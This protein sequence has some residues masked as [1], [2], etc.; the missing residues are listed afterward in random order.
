MTTLTYRTVVHASSCG[1]TDRRRRW[2]DS[3]SS[4]PSRRK[5]SRWNIGSRRAKYPRTCRRWTPPGESPQRQ[6]QRYQPTLSS[7]TVNIDFIAFHHQ[8]HYKHWYLIF[9]PVRHSRKR[10]KKLWSSLAHCQQVNQVNI[11]QKQSVDA[12]VR[13]FPSM[14]FFSKKHCRA[15]QNLQTQSSKKVI[16]INKITGHFLV[17]RLEFLHK[18]FCKYLSFVRVGLY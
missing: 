10:R 6:Y 17:N 5:I 13:K 8:P 15:F 12:F 4:W 2:S 3:P 16:R 14:Q 9:S 7:S 18:I 1:R 11:S